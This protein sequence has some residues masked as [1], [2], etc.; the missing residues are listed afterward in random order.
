MYFSKEHTFSSVTGFSGKIN[1]NRGA[2][3]TL[4]QKPGVF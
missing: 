2:I 3:K 1:L 4:R